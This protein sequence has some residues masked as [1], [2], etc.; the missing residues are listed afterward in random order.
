MRISATKQTR[1]PA[2]EGSDG[3]IGSR[4][5]RARLRPTGHR[6]GTEQLGLETHYHAPPG[7]VRQEKL[8]CKFT[9]DLEL[10]V[11]V[12]FHLASA[13]FS[14]PGREVCR[15]PQSFTHFSAVTVCQVPAVHF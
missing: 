7:N 9:F 5:K 4:A 11:R 12:P 6:C 15:N 1:T 8:L 13:H 3:Q 10:R 14:V 2:L